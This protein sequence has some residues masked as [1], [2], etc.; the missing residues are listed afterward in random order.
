MF[1]LFSFFLAFF[2]QNG[3]NNQTA[4]AVVANPAKHLHRAQRRGTTSE[5]SISILK[6]QTDEN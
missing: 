2:L 1:F 5:F 4:V 6:N 3:D